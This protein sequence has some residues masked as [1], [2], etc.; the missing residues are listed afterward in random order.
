MIYLNKKERLEDR[1]GRLNLLTKLVV[2]DN[3]QASF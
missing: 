1:C 3:D 2:C